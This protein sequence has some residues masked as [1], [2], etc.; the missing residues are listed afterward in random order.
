MPRADGR[1]V[2]AGRETAHRFAQRARARRRHRQRQWIVAGLVIVA[3][4]A[5]GVVVARSA[6][7]RVGTV[8]VSGT[9]RQP[10]DEVISAAAVRIG[11]P[12]WSLDT[13][14]IRDRV[15]TLPRIRT[16]SVARHWPRTVRITI[17]ERQPVAVV[18]PTSGTAV[19]V[20]SGAAEIERVA[21][22]PAG[23]LRITL[24]RAGLPDTAEARRPLV[25]AAL[26]VAVALPPPVRARTGVIR[27]ES[28]EQIELVFTDGTIVQWGSADRSERKAAVLSALLVTPHSLYDVRAPETPAV[29]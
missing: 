25:S 13:A 15:A 6:L 3:I 20:D 17:T 7:V 21:A 18:T 2:V 19:V 10:V 12:M 29:R 9:S 14:A 28:T 1:D 23:L 26:A 24:T 5:S 27:V 22:E 16:V 4:A 11:T 8:S